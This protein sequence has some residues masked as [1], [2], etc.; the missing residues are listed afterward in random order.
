MW[1]PHRQTARTQ[2]LAAG[3]WIRY[4]LPLLSR[5][6]ER[7]NLT[8]LR[9]HPDRSRT[10]IPFIRRYKHAGIAR[11]YI[12][13]RIDRHFETE[14]TNRSRW[15]SIHSSFR[16]QL[17][18]EMDRQFGKSSGTMVRR[19]SAMDKQRPEC[20]LAEFDE[21]VTLTRQPGFHRAD[22]NLLKR[23]ALDGKSITHHRAS[24]EP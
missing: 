24:G 7:E 3:Q 8:D 6:T 1:Q 19:D 9:R 18:T 20:C 2:P 5:H 11:S 12:C 23:F 4:R 13:D 21:P 22:L 10:G 17:F 16:R 14:I 15:L